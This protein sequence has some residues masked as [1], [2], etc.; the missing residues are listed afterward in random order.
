MTK[1]LY[2]VANYRLPTERAHGLQVVKTCEALAQEG[3]AVTILAPKRGQRAKAV[4]EYYGVPE[5]FAIRY[6]AVWDLT[7]K[8]PV[9]GFFVQSVSFA[10]SVLRFLQRTNY[11]GTIYTRD[12]MALYVLSLLSTNRIVFELHTMPQRVMPWHRMTWKRAAHIVVIS[13]GLMGTLKNLGFSDEKITVVHDG[14]DDR[15]MSP[16]QDQETLRRTLGLPEDKIIVMYC[17]SMMRW[18][19]VYTLAEAA[20]MLPAKYQVVAVGGTDRDFES[21]SRYIREKG[22]RNIELRSRVPH[23]T[24]MQYEHAA[25]ILV[26]PN[27]AHDTSSRL[28]TSPLKFFEYMASKRPIVASDLPS[29]REI[30]DHFSGINFCA[31]DDSQLLAQAI[32]NTEP[33]ARY[34]RDLT[35]YSWR[36]RARRLAPLV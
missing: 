18:K 5:V 9:I 4:F 1:P 28:Y 23:Q 11:A 22:I 12:P 29:L 2:Y 33:T 3:F 27:S 6:L 32:M 36:A 14:Y 25:D 26:L 15:L 8:I 24:I 35:Q 7:G 30:G 10:F 17:G 20:H 13:G 19:G 31:P 21:L 16:D 34:R